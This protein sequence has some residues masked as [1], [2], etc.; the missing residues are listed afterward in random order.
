MCSATVLA[1]VTRPR[2]WPSASC[3][4]SIRQPRSL[5]SAVAAV[6]SHPASEG[7]GFTAVSRPR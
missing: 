1:R 3:A 2:A 4:R 5:A 7:P 6:G